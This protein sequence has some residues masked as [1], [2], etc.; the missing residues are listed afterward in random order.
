MRRHPFALGALV[1]VVLA[2]SASAQSSSALINE[3][4][5]KQQPLQLEGTLPQAI[6]T[7]AEKTGVRIEIA[8]GAYDLLPWGEQTTI[9]ARIE[10]QTLRDVPHEKRQPL[11][12]KRSRQQSLPAAIA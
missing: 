1:L 4:L 2:S 11:A 6:Q 8:P 12:R 5:D 9:K 10:N 3:A 7:I